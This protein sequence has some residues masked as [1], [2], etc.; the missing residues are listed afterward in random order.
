MFKFTGWDLEE[1]LQIEGVENVIQILKP[2]DST[3]ATS[4]VRRFDF[5]ST[6]MRSS[7]ITK[8]GSEYRSFV[9]GAPEAISELCTSNVPDDYLKV[10]EQKTRDGYRVIA[11]AT[12]VLDI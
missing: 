9:K 10:M 12:K 1:P 4:L 11:L 7:V 6:L 3:T 5:T 2:K 8:Q